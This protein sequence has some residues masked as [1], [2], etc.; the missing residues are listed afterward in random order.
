MLTSYRSTTLANARDGASAYLVEFGD[1]LVTWAQVTITGPDG[2][3]YL[4]TFD[5]YDE[6]IDAL[7][8]YGF[9]R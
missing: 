3:E 9:E 2:R 6:A 7:S 5:S 4:S 1:H 8:G